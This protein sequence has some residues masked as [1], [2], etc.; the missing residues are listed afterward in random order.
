M[1][2]MLMQRDATV[3]IVTAQRAIF[4]QFTYSADISSWPPANSE[5]ILP[6]M[7]RTGGGVIE[8][9]INASLDG[10]LVGVVDC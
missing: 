1:P 9:G 6:Q 3:C 7:V 2:L 10:L 4:A 5:L 8:V